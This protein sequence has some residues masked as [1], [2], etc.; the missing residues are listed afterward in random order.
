[1]EQNQTRPSTIHTD[2]ELSPKGPWKFLTK[3]I[4]GGFTAWGVQL[5]LAW[6]AFYAL[7]ALSWFSHLRAKLVNSALAENWGEA[8]SAGDI[9]E[10][11]ENGGLRDDFFGPWVLV[12]GALAL[13]WALW[14]GWK[15]QTGAVGLCASIAPW[16]ASVPATLAI[17]FLPLWVLHAML[18]ETLAFLGGLGIQPLA[19][20]DFFGG[21]LLRMAFASSLMLQWWLCRLD[22]AKRM[23]KSAEEWKAH[24]KDSFL[25]LWVHPVQWGNIIFFGVVARAGLT[26]GALYVGWELGAKSLSHLWAFIA[27]QSLVA[28]INAWIIGWALRVAALYWKNDE[29]VRTEIRAL[30]IR[31]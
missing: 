2:D 6:I 5:I 31:M 1:M 30:K 20:M 18:W 17:G 11:M 9:W 21:P 13:L 16:L 19:W 10:I 23:P 4:P 8:I 24:I 12:V 28:A 22:M 7:T 27:L 15:M 25:R 26:F 29:A 3:A 14:A